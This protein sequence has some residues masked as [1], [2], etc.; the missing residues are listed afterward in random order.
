MEKQISKSWA[1]EREKTME[2]RPQWFRKVNN[3]SA[4]IST[5]GCRT[6]LLG[7]SSRPPF[8]ISSGTFGS[9]LWKL[10]KWFRNFA[11]PWFVSWFLALKDKP[12]LYK[13]HNIADAT[14][15]AWGL[16]SNKREVVS[17]VWRAK[18]SRAL[19]ISCL[20]FERSEIRRTWLN[21]S[22]SGYS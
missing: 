12:G 13:P 8:S 1:G 21:F 17:S 7:K 16:R 10:F 15:Q 19:C 18:S 2:C 20:V 9:S 3:R 4:S 6:D 14:N 5:L 22:F 11:H